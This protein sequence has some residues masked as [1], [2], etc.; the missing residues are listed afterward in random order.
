MRLYLVAVCALAL[1]CGGPG[2]SDGTAGANGKAGAEGAPGPA[3][4]PGADGKDGAEGPAGPAG[5][6][7][8]VERYDEECT[9]EH[10]RIIGGVTYTELYA[11]HDFEN[12]EDVTTTIH[13]LPG[14]FD[15]AQGWLPGTTHIATAY[16]QFAGKKAFYY[17]GT[18][19]QLNVDHVTFSRWSEP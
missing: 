13:M 4:P 2:A 16:T 8:K 6:G 14:A 12:T 11:V 7:P 17:C 15:A 5:A 19:G 18:K 1:G 3:G 9:Y 10:E